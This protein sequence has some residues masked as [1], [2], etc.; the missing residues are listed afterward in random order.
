MCI[1]R[2]EAFRCNVPDRK[3]ETEFD[4]IRQI[5]EEQETNDEKDDAEGDSNPS[6]SAIVDPGLLAL[7]E[8]NPDCIGWIKIE[9]TA[10]DYPVM[11][12]PEEKNFCF[13]R[14]FEKEYDVSGT[15]F[16]SESCD[17]EDA[18]NQIIYGHHMSSRKMFAALDCYKSEKIL[19][20][21]NK[22]MEELICYDQINPTQ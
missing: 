20:G 16:L 17:P 2:L 8:K 18:D 15:P 9:G 19:P 22:K 14:N 6:A 21:N 12:S 11:Y 7:H 5:H 10:I 13:R 4:S 3:S 1:F